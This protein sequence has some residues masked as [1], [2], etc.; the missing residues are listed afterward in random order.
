MAQCYGL[1][2][3]GMMLSTHITTW[4]VGGDLQPLG[5]EASCNT[6][7]LAVPQYGTS[8]CLASA[9]QTFQHFPASAGTRKTASHVSCG[10]CCGQPLRPPPPPLCDT[11]AQSCLLLQL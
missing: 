9:M 7:E 3:I 11:G 6:G 1:H 8:M 4:P 10:G 5:T 2:C